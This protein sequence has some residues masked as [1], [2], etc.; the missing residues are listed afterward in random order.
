M[1]WCKQIVFFFLV[2]DIP[3]RRLLTTEKVQFNR[4]ALMCG[5]LIPFQYRDFT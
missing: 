5:R 2:V 1:L 4:A 3:E